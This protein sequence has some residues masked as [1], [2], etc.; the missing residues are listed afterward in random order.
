MEGN[1]QHLRQ[2]FE[3]L[4]KIIFY[5][6]VAAL[7][8]CLEAILVTQRLIRERRSSPLCQDLSSEDFVSADALPPE[9][10]WSHRILWVLTNITYS[11]ELVITLGDNRIL[12]YLSPDSK[13]S[14]S[15]KFISNSELF[16]CL[17]GVLQLDYLC[18]QK[19]KSAPVNSV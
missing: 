17:L 3:R 6:L 16:N 15:L 12:R 19:S 14:F 2:Y 18:P 10:P 8:F 13:V 11:L 7:G 4:L 5:R 9:L 1:F